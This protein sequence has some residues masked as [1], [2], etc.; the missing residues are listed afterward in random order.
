MP[1][2]TAASHSS[3]AS[4]RV[5]RVGARI[6][7]FRSAALVSFRQARASASVLKDLRIVLRSRGEKTWAW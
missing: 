3:A 6:V 7:P 1:P 5:V 4:S 2:L